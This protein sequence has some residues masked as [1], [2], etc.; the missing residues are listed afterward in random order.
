MVTVARVAVSRR[1]PAGASR[2]VTITSWMTTGAP[3][4]AG[5]DG[6]AGVVGAGTGGAATGAAGAGVVTTGAG[7]DVVGAGFAAGALAAARLS[8]VSALTQPNPYSSSRPDGPSGMALR[9]RRSRTC[10]GVQL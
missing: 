9:S 6:G 3:P 2:S 5:A 7:A 1:A 8:A 10:A 4:G